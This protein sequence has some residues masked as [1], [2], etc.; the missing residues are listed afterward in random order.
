VVSFSTGNMLVRFGR[1]LAQTRG[2]RGVPILSNLGFDV[3]AF[4]C[5]STDAIREK[6]FCCR[7][8]IIQGRFA[9]EMR[10]LVGR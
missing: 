3:A 10:K 7:L 6:S 1:D 2:P 8:W 9:A 5:P 4:R